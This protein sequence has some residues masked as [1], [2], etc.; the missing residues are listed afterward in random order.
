MKLGGC[1]KIRYNQR[2]FTI[3]KTHKIANPRTTVPFKHLN[4]MQAPAKHLSNSQKNPRTSARWRTHIASGYLEQ[5]VTKPRTKPPIGRSPSLLLYDKIRRG[6]FAARS[7]AS[8]TSAVMRCIRPSVMFVDSVKTNKRISVPNGNILTG[9]SPTPITGASN[10]VR[11]GRNRNSE[12]IS[13]F[14]AC[15]Q[16]CD[17]LGVINTT[18]PDHGPASCDTYRWQQA[19]ELNGR[20]RRRDVYDKKSQRYAQDNRTEPLIARSDK[21]V[22]YVTNNKRLLDILYC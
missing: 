11:V 19:A 16:R 13:G 6:I 12:S 5:V 8:A 15:C 17:R 4:R 7:Y 2:I 21:S 10:A 14:T 20:R 3:L 9:I 22:A 18:S 1:F